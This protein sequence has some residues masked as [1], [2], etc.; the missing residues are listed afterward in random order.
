MTAKILYRPSF[1]FLSSKNEEELGWL[2]K[3]RLPAEKGDEQKEEKSSSHGD[4]K[5]GF[6]GFRRQESAKPGERD[7]DGV[8]E[9]PE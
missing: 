1:R 2:G 7:D 5:D 8:K 9:C 3:R 6:V 4:E